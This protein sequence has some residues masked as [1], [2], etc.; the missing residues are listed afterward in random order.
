M[1]VVTSLLGD[2]IHPNLITCTHALLS[3]YIKIGDSLHL[4]VDNEVAFCLLVE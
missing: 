3:F 4:V 2:T 1:V